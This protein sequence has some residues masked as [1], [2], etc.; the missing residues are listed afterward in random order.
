M[1]KISS[2]F[3]GAGMPDTSLLMSNGGMA[4]MMH[5]MSQNSGIQQMMQS[6]MGGNGGGGMPNLSSLF[7]GGMGFPPTPNLSQAKPHK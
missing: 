2:L 1:P 5:Q 3:G 4:E 6:M 7:G